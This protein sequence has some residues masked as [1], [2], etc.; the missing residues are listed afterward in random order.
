[1]LSDLIETV[2]PP[3]SEEIIARHFG[4]GKTSLSRIFSHVL[5]ISF[6]QYLN[7]LRINYAEYLLRSTDLNMMNIA[8]ECGYQNQQTFYRVFKS[9]HGCTPHEFRVANSRKQF[10]FPPLN[11]FEHLPE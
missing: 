7:S 1:M 6:T 9:V 11:E 2:L 8:V 10:R 5:K 3:F 4:I